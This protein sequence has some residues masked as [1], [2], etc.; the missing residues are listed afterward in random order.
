MPIRDV[1]L[2]S[3]QTRETLGENA[4]NNESTGA[5]WVGVLSGLGAIGT[6]A[7]TFYYIIPD[8]K[9][10]DRWQALEM[11]ASAV[12]IAFVVGAMLRFTLA[13]LV[14][15]K[16]SAT[17]TEVDAALRSRIAPM[18]LLIGCTAIVALAVV[19]IVSFV[20]LAPK[21][22]FNQVIGPKIDV[23][24][25]SVF[26][27]VLPVVAT[28]VGTV[29]AFYFG[30]ESFRQAAQSTRDVLTQQLTSERKITDLMVPYERIAKLSA[31]N[32]DEASKLLMLDVVH[33]MS[34]AATRVIVFNTRTQTP[35]YVIRS[36]SPPMPRNW[37]T[38]DYK[39]GPDIKDKSIK[40]YI[41]A[42]SGKNKADALNFRFINENSTP[43]AALAVMT[44][45]K[46]DDLFI[47]KDGQPTSRV[48][49]WV[50]GHDLLK[51]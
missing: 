6:L 38:G 20:V 11:L 18:V 12:A 41:D 22:P 5:V 39:E 45:E 37:I 40:E 26:T 17:A 8:V 43:D 28:W 50:S 33:M 31:E 16:P 21:P 14:M 44:K 27:T 7:A 3:T 51:K 4:M 13:P 42:D 35:I 2:K 30:S 19:L 47:T 29:L 36:W 23:L 46:I 25:L 9:T 48:I 34:E 32:Q 24:V 15:A 1:A 10:G 49:G